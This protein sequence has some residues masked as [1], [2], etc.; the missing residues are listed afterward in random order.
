[1]ES[2]HR[3]GILAAGAVSGSLIGRL[4]SRRRDVGPVCAVS[5]RVASRIANT[6]R[7]GYP[8][9]TADELGE[10]RGVLFHSPPEH[11]DNLL[12]VL[13]RAEIDWT[14]KALVFC[15]CFASQVIRRRFEAR[16]ASTAVARLFGVPPRIIVEGDD[17]AALRI[18]QRMARELRLKAVGISQGAGDLFDAAV[19]LGG[20]AITPLID[21]AASLLRDAGIRDIEA[22]RFA[23]SLFEQ[24]A[25][26]YAHSG[27]QSWV[28]YVRSPLVKRLE[29][30]IA[31]SG[32]HL[33]R[34]LRELVLFGFETFHKHDEV[35]AE[36]EPGARRRTH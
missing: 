29:A 7:A 5:Y 33:E 31:A 35:G 17:G 18:V 36:L 11:L 24:T 30:Q 26:D 13:G 34:V 23:S 16:G 8:V 2:R 25:R 20:A 10:V 12:E 27:K 6:L 22:A 19:T 1:M 28:W 21:C 9:R 3:Y 4:P 32:P 15:D 14:G